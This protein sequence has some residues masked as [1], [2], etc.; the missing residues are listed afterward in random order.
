MAR[1]AFDPAEVLLAAGRAREND[2]ERL[3]LVRRVE[4]DAEQVEDLLGG[5][6]PAGKHDDA[7]A[8]AHECLEPLLDVRQDHQLVHDRIGRLGRHD[9]G[10]G[11]PDVA[12]VVER[13][14][15]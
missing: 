2:R 14:F 15:A 6:C 3:L 4:K 12:S 1:N 9:A 8:G 13:C 5:A 10:L 7:V 11:E